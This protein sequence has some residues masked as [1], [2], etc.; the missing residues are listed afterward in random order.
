[1]K[2]P[3]GLLDGLSSPEVTEMLSELACV[4]DSSVKESSLDIS[5]IAESVDCLLRFD[6]PM[7]SV[8]LF[9]TEGKLCRMNSKTVRNQTCVTVSYSV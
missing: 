3:L 5:A 6:A 1:M 7:L 9:V 2:L 8:V 4:C